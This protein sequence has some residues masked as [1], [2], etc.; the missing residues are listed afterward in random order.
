MGY[1]EL[2][3]HVLPGV[4]DGPASMEESI[5]LA[6]AAAAE[7]TRTVVAT[8]H[9]Q[10]GLVTDVRSLPER[11]EEVNRALRE[12]RVPV[13]VLCGG[14][15]AHPMV[16][17]LSAAELDVIA[18]GPRGRRWVLLEAPLAGLDDG[19]TRAAAEVREHGFAVVVAHP[20]RALPG[21]PDGWRIIERELAAGS[22]LQVNA[23]SV[24]GVYGE[25]VRRH[26]LRA[27]AS[28][29]PVALASDAHGPLR[30]PALQLGL[31]ALAYLGVTRPE[32]LAGS[33]PAALLKQGLPL[34][35]S[36]LAA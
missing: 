29:A 26:A 7:G 13:K 33:V 24:A 11:L 21:V 17:R 2:H 5:E 28:A 31:E 25:E 4:D 36:A 27:I 30:P 18:H 1:T 6:R 20:E 34:P 16:A 10:D 14:E 22:A 19:Y 9:V 12:A 8:P 15:L 35:P 32:R 3:F 23:W